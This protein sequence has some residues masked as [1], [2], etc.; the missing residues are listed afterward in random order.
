M[1]A[2]VPSSLFHHGLREPH[3]RQLR[4]PPPIDVGP[5]PVD[6]HAGAGAGAVEGEAEVVPLVGAELDRLHV[7]LVAAVVSRLG[8]KP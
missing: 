4:V 2:L 8:Q 7:V 6:D 5:L 1:L 3:V